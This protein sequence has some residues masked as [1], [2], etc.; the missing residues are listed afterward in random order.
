M[1]EDEIG[2]ACYRHGRKEK[3]IQ[4][5]VATLEEKR[6]LGRNWMKFEAN[7]ILDIR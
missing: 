6:A 1:K 4:A 3:C 7:L 5:F 2:G